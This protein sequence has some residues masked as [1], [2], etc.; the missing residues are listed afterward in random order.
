MEWLSTMN[1]KGKIWVDCAII[2]GCNK[3]E[4]YSEVKE[5]ELC[6]IWK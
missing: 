2:G 1:L 5:V 6:R 4:V 3:S